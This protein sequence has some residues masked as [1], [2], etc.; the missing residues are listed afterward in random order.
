[1]VLAA[2]IVAGIAAALHVM[3]FVFES[4]LWTKPSIFPRFGVASQEQ[5]DTTKAMAY[6]QGFY[7]L[8]LAI[9]TVIGIALLGGAGGPD[10]VI[11][12]KAMML[13][14]TG[15]MALAGIVLLTTGRHY[16]R[17]AAIQFIPAAAGFVLT[18][19]A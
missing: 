5:A 1:M 19:F 18:L 9:G 12:G 4:V 13:L 17:A 6:N 8:F 15:S 16:L 3:F 7:N 11:A 14:T 10:L 2:Q